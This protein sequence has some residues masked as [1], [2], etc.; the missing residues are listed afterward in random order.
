MPDE[1]I[2]IWYDDREKCSGEVKIMKMFN[3]QIEGPVCEV[4]V[5]THKKVMELF[6]QGVSPEEALIEVCGKE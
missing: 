5:E 2:C 3:D 4:H 6:K 1:L